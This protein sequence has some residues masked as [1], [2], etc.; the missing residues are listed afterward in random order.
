MRLAPGR[1]ETFAFAAEP[2]LF[3]AAAEGP[4]KSMWNFCWLTAESDDF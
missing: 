1:M 2:S 4:M 3:S